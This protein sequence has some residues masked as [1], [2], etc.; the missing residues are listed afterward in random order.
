MPGAH[1]FSSSTQIHQ[2][3]L[4]D[5]GIEVG[6]L[7]TNEQAKDVEFSDD[8]FGMFVL[9]QNGGQIGTEFPHSYI[10]HFRLDKSFDV[11]TA[12]K[13]GRWNVEGFGNITSNTNKTGVPTGFSFSPDG[14]ML[15]MVQKKGGAGVDQ[16]NRFDLECPYGLAE[17][18][19]ATTSVV[20][21]T[22]ELAKQNISINISTIFRRFE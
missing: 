5:L 10:Y 8:G 20:S 16:V 4:S 22:V 13:I 15:F 9:I 1:D 21:T 19:S 2:V 14:M 7:S 12:T 6:K 17:C 3:D 18:V 11:S